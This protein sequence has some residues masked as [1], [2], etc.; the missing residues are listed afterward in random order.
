MRTRIEAGS[1]L[2]QARDLLRALEE[3][4]ARIGHPAKGDAYHG[5]EPEEPRLER[6]IEKRRE[7]LAEL[8][9]Q[10]LERELEQEL[11]HDERDMER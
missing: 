2:R 1:A 9:R 10:D 3:L 7:R 5:R 8:R 4:G 6:E 11:N